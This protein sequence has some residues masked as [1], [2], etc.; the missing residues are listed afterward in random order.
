MTL[1]FSQI[2]VSLSDY[3]PRLKFL[4]SSSEAIHIPISNP[5]PV[6][7]EESSW[8]SR[9]SHTSVLQLY[10]HHSQTPLGEG[11][12]VPQ[13]SL[14]VFNTSQDVPANRLVERFLR[15]G[16]FHRSDSD[17]YIFTPSESA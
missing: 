13:V 15:S 10:D 11:S 2:Q 12:T 3:D 9:R 14:T 17:E 4:L 8:S 6:K 7:A 5:Q 16:A 1:G